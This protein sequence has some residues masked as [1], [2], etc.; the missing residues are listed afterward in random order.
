MKLKIYAIL[1]IGL[2][3]FSLNAMACKSKE[4]TIEFG[5]GGGFTGA[6]KEYILLSN[7]DLFTA[8]NDTVLG[9]KIKTLDK[10]TTKQLFEEADKL[11]PGTWTVNDPGNMTYYL[12]YFD[13]KNKM[14]AKWGGTTTP[15]SDNLKKF[16]DH[17]KSLISK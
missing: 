11:D 5:S 10:A 8:T 17:I 16:Y 12:N 13:G 15:P 2:L 1:G 7:G 4:K 9:E 3:L 14:K 6:Y